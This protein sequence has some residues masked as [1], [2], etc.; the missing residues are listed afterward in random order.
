[1]L[2][3]YLLHMIQEPSPGLNRD[4]KD[5]PGLEPIRSYEP[6]VA[7]QAA[8]RLCNRDS[9]SHQKTKKLSYEKIE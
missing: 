8:F 7:D 9:S 3:E 4:I 5:R 2:L 6:R 1:M